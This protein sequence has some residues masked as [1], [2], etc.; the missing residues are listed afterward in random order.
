M[1]L[2]HHECLTPGPGIWL[3]PYGRVIAAAEL[4]AGSMDTA[5]SATGGVEETLLLLM[6]AASAFLGAQCT[7]SVQGAAEAQALGEAPPLR[8]W[9]SL[10]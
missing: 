6:M 3:R 7:G 5:P 10:V 1:Q 4:Q 9:P 8:C 2:S